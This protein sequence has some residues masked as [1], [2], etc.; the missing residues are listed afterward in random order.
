[1]GRR[2]VWVLGTGC[3]GLPSAGCYWV[4]LSLAPSWLDRR[5]PAGHCA[6]SALGWLHTCGAAASLCGKDP[7]ALASPHTSHRCMPAPV[8]PCPAPQVCGVFIQSTDN[9]ARRRDHLEGKQYLG[10][11]VGASWV[12]PGCGGAIAF[13]FA[14]CKWNVRLE[15]TAVAVSPFEAATTRRLCFQGTRRGHPSW[16]GAAPKACHPACLRPPFPLPL[17]LPLPLPSLHPR[18]L[19]GHP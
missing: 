2:C 5:A 19:A 17:P 4:L 10:G 8:A 1:M 18:R 13:P 9:E 15:S 6:Q 7:R 16:C 14:A 12:G 3:W 11:W